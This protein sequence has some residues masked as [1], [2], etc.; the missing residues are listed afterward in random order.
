MNPI[1]AILLGFTLGVF[2]GPTKT[3]YDEHTTFQCPATP[4][5]STVFR[6][7]QFTDKEEWK[8]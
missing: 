4:D 1:V 7:G 6:R 2:F 3:I 5:S 8:A